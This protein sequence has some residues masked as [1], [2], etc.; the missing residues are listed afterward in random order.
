MSPY[1]H[2]EIEQKM[3]SQFRREKKFEI[4]QEKKSNK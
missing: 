1:E 3:K 4:E 2:I